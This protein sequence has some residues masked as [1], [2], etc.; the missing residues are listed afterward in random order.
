M[1]TQR[2]ERTDHP[3]IYR[4]HR[5]HCPGGEC[6]C[7][8]YQAVVWDNG[9]RK[10]LRRHFDTFNEAHAWRRRTY[11]DLRPTRETVKSDRAHDSLRR[12]ITLV[13]EA[14]DCADVAAHEVLDDALM[15]LHHAED[16]LMRAQAH[17]AAL[18]SE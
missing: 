10:L 3:G 11:R 13:S 14:R 16:E 9:K 7:S 5:R 6:D 17:I 2:T 1:T 8:T 12:T 4:F 18:L 15:A